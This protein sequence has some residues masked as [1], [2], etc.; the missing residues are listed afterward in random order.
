MQTKYLSE[1]EIEEEL[2]DYLYNVNIK[3]AVL[4][5]GS[6][7]SGKTYFI[8]QYI[9]KLEKNF[10]ESKKDKN[11]NVKKPI[12][13]S[14]YGINSIPEIKNKILLSLIKSKKVKQLL[15]LLDVGLEVG[16]DFISSKTFIKNS[17]NKLSKV[18]GTLYK[19]D[20]LIIVFDDLERCNININSVLGY[21][22]E[23]VEHND[24]KVIIVADET[25]IGKVNYEKNLELKY[26]LSLSDKIDLE[27]KKKKKYTW[28]TSREEKKSTFTKDEIIKRTKDIF[29]ED[30]IY[31][32]IKEKL[33]GKIIYYRTN[34]SDV[35][36]IFVEKIIINVDANATA[37]RNK[38]IFLKQLEDNNYW[39][40]RTIQFI[41]Q[42]FN[43]I[44]NETVGIIDF[45]EIKL[46]YLNDVFSYCTIKSLKIKQGENTYNW[47][48]GQD[49]GTVYLGNELFD[50]AY[51]NYVVGFRFIDDYLFNSCIDKINIKSILI[52]Y[53]NMVM[54]EINNPNDPLYKL[55]TW[56]LIPENELSIIIDNL[57][58]KIKNNEYGLELYSKIV[59]FLSRIE[60][61]DVCV[62]K[63]KIAI[64]ELET[65]IK[66]KDIIGK[67]CEDTL[68]DGT[69][70]TTE[71][72]K[73]NI[74]KIRQ[75]VDE[76]ENND[77]KNAINSIFSSDNWGI[78]L[79]K[80]CETNRAK[81]LS[82]KE[83][84]YILDIDMIV[85]NIKNKSIEEIYEFWYS[86]QKIYSFSNIKE[87][88]ENDKEKL[89]ELKNVLEN[90]E[91][92]D[93][94][95]K[96]VINKISDFLVEVINNL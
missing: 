67:Y 29:N 3:Y 66:E 20:N 7:G 47:E 38:E 52:Q 92:V 40:L 11:N 19:I 54:N 6:W 62:E 72:Y 22:N 17:D 10:V 68:F 59:S 44:V 87:F 89:I 31:N 32:E 58:K 37:I 81:F 41:F 56:W 65:N 24:I 73:K 95:K 5:N 8:K 43:R 50:Y 71:L 94:V 75:L 35:Y 76:K 4:L 49:F 45:E 18:L 23:L 27:D 2:N 34:I 86:L 69:P 16:S 51:K 63:I 64:K 53:K 26:M 96:F 42:A 14:L 33:I 88:Y 15:P 48:K 55:K 77:I 85:S 25:K 46:I 80:Y 84:A 12:Y 60:E 93:K 79:K 39:N 13:I 1:K 21:I 91:D 61:M 36:D 74:Q 78:K 90:I 70:K 30:N 83:F 28:D 9:E 57:I 82:D